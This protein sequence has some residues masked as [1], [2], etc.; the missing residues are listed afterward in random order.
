MDHVRIRTSNSESRDIDDL[1]IPT[2]S[3]DAAAAA[4]QPGPARQSSRRIVPPDYL[5]Y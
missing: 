4:M 3:N 2:V 1:E 5:H